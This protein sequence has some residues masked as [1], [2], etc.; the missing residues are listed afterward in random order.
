[1]PESS[2]ARSDG[3]SIIEVMMASAVLLVGFIGVIQALTIGS[4]SL[5]TVRKQGVAGQIIA[6]EIEKLRGS[7]WSTIA[8]LP[9]TATIAI[10]PAG[11]ITGDLT[12]FA[13]SNR[14]TDATDDQLALSRLANGLTCALTRVR[15]RPASA[16]A[17]SVTFVKVTY[18]VT[19]R[20]NT[21][22]AHR[23]VAETYL[24]LNGLQLSYQQS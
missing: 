9:D 21:G 1:M 11:A 24:T 7:P 16:T 2:T 10:G 15:L 17:A 22:R 5:D 8:D 20:S 19:W 23:Q 4:E 12:A 3:F 14:T 13:L 18:T 6:G